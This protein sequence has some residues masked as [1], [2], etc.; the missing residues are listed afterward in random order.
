MPPFKRPP[1]FRRCVTEVASQ[2]L[3][4]PPDKRIAKAFAI[5]TT[6]LRGK[7]DRETTPERQR[8]IDESYEELLARARDYRAAHKR[9]QPR[10]R[11]NP[12]SEEHPVSVFCRIL[13]IP[14]P[15]YETERTEQ[16]VLDDLVELADL[17]ASD[18]EGKALY[19]NE[20]KY[21]YSAG[22]HADRAAFHADPDNLS[23]Q[24]VALE[25]ALAY[26]DALGAGG[27]ERLFR[28]AIDRYVYERGHPRRR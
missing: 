12:A 16:Q 11:R 7:P 28:A 10:R 20:R 3:E 23:P 17:F 6:S 25:A 18:V 8:V 24:D 4:M 1:K 22:L 27:N 15:P 5:C 21:A 14:L 26:G 2:Q 13:R 9:R 19:P